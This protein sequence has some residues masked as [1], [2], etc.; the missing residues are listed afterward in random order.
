MNT[1]LIIED[2]T[3]PPPYGVRL[4]DRARRTFLQIT[5]DR[6][7]EVVVP[8]YKRMPNIQRLLAEKRHW[9]ERS[10]QNIVQRPL[11]ESLSPLPL[12]KPAFVECTAILKSWEITYEYKP[13]T[14]RLKLTELLDKNPRLHFSGNIEDTKRCY[15]LLKKWLAKQAFIS[16]SIWLKELSFTT[17]LIYQRL[18]IRGQTTLWG[19][20]NTHRTISLNYKL[21]FL[22]QSLAKHVLLHELC[23]T[24][25]LNH[26]VRFW[27]QLKK[28]DEHYLEHKKMLKKAEVHLPR[29]LS[30]I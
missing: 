20:C 3:W 1:P 7:L 11:Q 18:I 22:P 10:L 17:N 19:S 15:H 4:S 12:E 9:I 27:Q 13:A 16:F 5:P 29:W 25:Y 6:G 28:W 2:I 14:Q 23:H 21:L 30:C 26:S 8:R 24:K